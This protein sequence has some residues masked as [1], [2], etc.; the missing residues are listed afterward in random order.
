[1]DDNTTEQA[2][3]HQAELEQQEQLDPEQLQ[4]NDPAC[5]IWLD[6]VEKKDD[7]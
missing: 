6:S 7:R 3:A 1:M 4:K 5:N 2:W